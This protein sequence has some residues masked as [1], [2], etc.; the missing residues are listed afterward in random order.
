MTF[1]VILLTILVVILTIID[2]MTPVLFIVFLILKL[3]SVITWSWFLVCLPIII[4]G[5]ALILTIIFSV[6]AAF[7]D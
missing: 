4:F 1:L 6:I 5:I 7:L 3:C 2:Y